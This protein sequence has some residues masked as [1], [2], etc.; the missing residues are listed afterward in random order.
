MKMNKEQFLKTEFGGELESTI[1]AWDDALSRNRE[2]TANAHHRVTLVARCTRFGWLPMGGKEFSCFC[3][4]SSVRL[5][6]IG[7]WN[8]E[9]VFINDN[10]VSSWTWEL[11]M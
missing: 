10:G 9:E 2:D 7:D 11:R 1:T 5:E 8:E 6:R 4:G 3:K